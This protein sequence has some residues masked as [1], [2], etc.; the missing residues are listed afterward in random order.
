VAGN[1]IVNGAPGSFARL[2]GSSGDAPAVVEA[3]A[4]DAASQGGGE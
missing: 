2:L 4:S 3:D 1:W